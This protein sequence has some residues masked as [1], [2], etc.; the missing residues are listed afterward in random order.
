[1]IEI[2]DKTFDKSKGA[3]LIEFYASWCGKCQ[4]GLKKLEI[5]EAE[6]GMATGKCDFQ[7]NPKLLNRYITNGLPLYILFIDGK[8]IKQVIGLCDL[9]EEFQIDCNNCP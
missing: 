6:T 1:M 7:R 3:I 9:K 5:F 4:K 8:P 2:I